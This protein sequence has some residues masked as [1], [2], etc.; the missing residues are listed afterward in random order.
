MLAAVALTTLLIDTDCGFFGDD[1]ATL[2][3]LLHSPQVRVHSITTVSGNVWSE[4]ATRY[5]REILALLG[6]P[7]VPLHPGSALPLRHTRQMSDQAHAKWGPFEFRGAFEEPQPASTAPETAV[8]H[9]IQTIR[10]NP[11]QITIVAL[12]PLTNIARALQQAPDIA[13]KIPALVW[14]GGALR[15]PGNVS[16]TAEFNFWFDP[17]AASLVLRSPVPRKIMFGLDVC[18][19]VMLDKRR[20]DDIVRTVTPV[21]QRFR[22]DFGDR[23]PAFHKN[24]EARVSLWDS[25]V[26]AWVLQP[27]LFP[28]SESLSLDVVT[29]FG[30]DYGKVI[31]RPAHPPVQMITG[32]N[33]PKV[34]ALFSKL[35]KTKP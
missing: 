24:P 13:A 26:A 9:I 29:E 31:Q 33:A 1:G 28:A 11:G 23:F 25:L 21:T 16:K 12:G 18:N 17:E 34:L 27:A 15:V 14:M 20:F 2:T 3:M 30:P 6:R 8:A 32:V 19:Q 7:N 10:D 22:A 5:T 35:M 4:A